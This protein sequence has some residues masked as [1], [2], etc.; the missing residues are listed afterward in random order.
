MMRR[1]P[2]GPIV[3]AIPAKDEAERLG[4]CL[5]ALG[6]QR[7]ARADAVVL[8]VNNT[9]DGSA[10]VAHAL[11]PSLPFA[12]VVVEHDFPVVLACA[13][14]A[15]RM[16]MERAAVLA[17]E[18]GALL[19][20]DA[21]GRVALDWLAR[22]LAHLGAGV[23]AVAGCAEL[24]PAEARAI[25][26]RLHEDD[27]RECAYAAV[28]DEIASVLDPDPCDPWPRHMEHSG[29]SIGI[30]V[31]AYRSVGGIPPVPLG[32]DRAFFAAL[33]R[34]D[35]RI[36]H[37]PEVKVT[38]SGRT[39]GRAPG[40]MAD[41]IRRRLAAPDTWLDDTLEPAETAIRRARV[42]GQ[43][44]RAFAGDMG[45]G[46]RAEGIARELRLPLQAVTAA[47]RGRYLGEGWAAL[48]DSSPALMRVRMAV[49]GLPAETA[50]AVREREAL[51]RQR[52]GASWPALAAAAAPG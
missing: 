48:E 6:A 38:V 43:F 9:R 30:T 36:R 25:P 45:G 28:L 10:G 7:G 51:R 26:A 21:D 19:T 15:R 2:G 52:G 34:A 3:I 37:A 39:D 31:A 12:L 46:Q 20:T 32:E 49:A 42:R 23:D 24:D 1:L 8:V 18:R 27:A 47:L 50:R 5:L 40:G 17:G 14:Q 13:G 16:A 4:A 29:A 11:A 35:T 33:R 41:T 22:N 44:R